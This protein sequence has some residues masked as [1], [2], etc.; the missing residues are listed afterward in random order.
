MNNKVSTSQE[1]TCQRSK[2]ESLNHKAAQQAKKTGFGPPKIAIF[3]EIL[4]KK[5]LALWYKGHQSIIKL[6]PTA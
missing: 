3:K 4:C 1:E 6:C 2:G 5:G